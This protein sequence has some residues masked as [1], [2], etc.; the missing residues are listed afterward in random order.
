[1]NLIIKAL[2]KSFMLQ[3]DSQNTKIRRRVAL[4]PSIQTTHSRTLFVKRFPLNESIVTPEKIKQCFDAYGKVVYVG[5]NREQ[6]SEKFTGSAFVEFDS[7]AVV[8]KL[9]LKSVVVKYS[10]DDE[11]LLLRKGSESQQRR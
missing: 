1:M 4:P 6:H 3:F 2:S 8:E 5:L 10:K 7:E 11:G 9:T